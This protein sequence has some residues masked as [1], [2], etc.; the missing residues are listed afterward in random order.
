MNWFDCLLTFKYV[1]ELHS[2]AGAA[3]ELKTTTSVI[4]KRIQWLEAKLATSLFLRTTRK[5][6][7]TD[8]GEY[9]LKKIHPLL[10]EWHDIHAQII[11]FK[12]QPRGEI[13]ICMPPNFGS[14]WSIAKILFAFTKAHPHLRLYIKYTYEPIDLISQKIDVLIATEKYVLDTATTTGTKL[15]DFSY[16]CFASPGYIKKHGEPKKI[17]DLK[18]HN[19]IVFHN[20]PWEFAGKSHAVQGNLRAD[21][22]DALISA[23]VSDVGLIYIPPF[24]VEKELKQGLL[25]QVLTK[26]QSKNDKMM[27]Y[28]PKHAY[29]PR[30]IALFVDFI[31]KN[32]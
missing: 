21:S 5:V 1:A 13:V 22:A 20:S 31:R 32:Y 10:E 29:K 19:C 15:F 4:T 18:K 11:D 28:Y 23:C 9:L 6:T 27:I 8:T 16:Q 25:K 17:D 30:K 7:V 3:R 12:E 24:F 14:V 2:F 26:H